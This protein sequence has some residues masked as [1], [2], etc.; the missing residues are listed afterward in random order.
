MLMKILKR[1]IKWKSIHRV[2]ALHAQVERFCPVRC[3]RGC[4]KKKKKRKLL[5]ISNVFFMPL[6][7]RFQFYH[8]SKDCD[9]SGK[10]KENLK[11]MS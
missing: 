4:N 1:I 9:H 8:L 6:F 2:T 5:K 7:E 3:F 11:F 10:Q